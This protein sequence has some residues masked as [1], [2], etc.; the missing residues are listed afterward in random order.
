M[1]GDAAG[2]VGM[3]P[4]EPIFRYLNK[5]LK[6]GE[7]CGVRGADAI[8][9]SGVI[10]DLNPQTKLCDNIQLFKQKIPAK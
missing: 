4:A 5:G 8:T 10:Y 1:C 6:R 7:I 3:D 9:L 2:I